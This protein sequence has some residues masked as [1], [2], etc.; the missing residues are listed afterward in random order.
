MDGPALRDPRVAPLAA[1]AAGPGR[2]ARIAAAQ[3]LVAGDLAFALT[4][5]QDTSFDIWEEERGYHYYTQLVQA[6]ALAQ[7]ADW[8]GGFG[9]TSARACDCRI[10]A[11]DR[12][13]R[14]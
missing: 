10:A 13:A 12:S 9:R 7:G 4:H 6:E 8:L 5:A 3:E 14:L 2:N 11:R 1:R